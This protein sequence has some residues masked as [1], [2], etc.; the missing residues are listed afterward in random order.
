MALE[1]FLML[2]YPLFFVSHSQAIIFY[3]TLARP[4]L[5]LGFKPDL[6]S[7]TEGNSLGVGN[8]VSNICQHKEDCKGHKLH[9]L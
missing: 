5:F 6:S 8:E 7:K 4:S 1:I 3:L 9:F 2:A